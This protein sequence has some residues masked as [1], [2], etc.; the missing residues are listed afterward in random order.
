MKEQRKEQRKVQRSRSVAIIGLV[1]VSL[2]IMAVV[3]V[4]CLNTQ[5][6]TLDVKEGQEFFVEYGNCDTL[7]VS[8]IYRE[9]L[10]NKKGVKVEVAVE[11]EV[12]YDKLGTYELIYTA[13]HKGKSTSTTVKVIVQD[14][15]APKIELVKDPEHYTK[16][17]GEYVE[18]GFSAVDNYDGDITNK[19]YKEEKDGVVT[20][21]VKD[22]SGNVATV[23]R[24]IVYKDMVAPDIALVGAA[25]VNIQVGSKYTDEGV[26]ATDDCDGNITSKVKV[27]GKVDTSKAGNY[28]ITYSVADAAGNI[29]TQQRK[30]CVYKKPVTATEV[31][32]G[33]KVVYLTFDD[34]PTLHTERLLN[35]L[36][37]YNVKATF[38]VTGQKSAYANMIGE[39]YRKGHT[40][41]L[42]TYTH[43]YAIYKSE[44]TYYADLKKINDLV[45]AQTGKQATLIRFP[46]G[47]SN[48]ISM[49][50]SNGIMTKLSES[51]S[52]YGYRYCD[53][54]VSSGD[55]SSSSTKESVISNVISGIKKNNV[56]V[57]LMHDTKESTVAAVEDIIVWGL[58]NGYT[59]L[60]MDETTPLVH[61]K[62]AN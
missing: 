14:T 55:G 57:V 3:V 34:G 21:S 42:H 35:T 62:V 53:W 31:K 30:V 20:Y 1:T 51:I 37:K 56:S 27:E 23:V 5:E 17:N 29:S 15:I 47:S 61:H 19:V 25:T 18:E 11:G 43:D 36:D 7:N 8:A 4:M 41:A 60:P 24:N 12:D 46:G 26:I 16:P 10:F 9:K 40:I 44:E 32:P 6:L 52:Y 49:N 48:T 58:E 28:T 2:L 22:S 39:T 59:F 38:F 45:V 50:Y 54:N 33:N 13:N